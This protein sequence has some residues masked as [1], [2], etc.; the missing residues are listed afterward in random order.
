VIETLLQSLKR[1]I[2]SQKKTTEVHKPFVVRTF[3]L[4]ADVQ[5]DREEMYNEFR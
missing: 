1:D 3:D 5:L 4:G 2:L